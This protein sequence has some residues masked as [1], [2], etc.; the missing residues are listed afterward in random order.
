M[1]KLSQYEAVP[2]FNQTASALFKENNLNIENQEDFE[3]LFPDQVT[4]INSYNDFFSQISILKNT[5]KFIDVIK[6]HN[7][8]EPIC[9]LGD[10]DVDGIMATTI[11]CHSLNKL[12]YA[13][14][15]IIPNR[16][17]DGY[18]M[19]TEALEKDILENQTTLFI[20]V[21]NGITAKESVSKVK[22]L[23]AEIII[24]DH[25]LP[26]ATLLP[27]TLIIDPKYNQDE[28]SDICGAYVAFK[29]CF[30]LYNQ[31]SPE[32]LNVIETL[33][34]LAGIATIADMMPALEE[35]RQLIQMTMN[36]INEVK[37]T[38]QKNSPLYKILY[39]LG[40]QNFFKSDTMLATEELISYSVGPAINAISRVNG[41]VYDV[42]QK[43][44]FCLGKPWAYIPSYISMN[45]ARQ[46]MSKE[47]FSD[48]KFDKNYNLSQV[49]IY[50][51]EEYEYNIKGILG[52]IA[53]RV[54]NKFKIVSLIGSYKDNGSV[55]FS[56]RSTPNYDLHTGID[57]LKELL[58][59]LGIN[60]GGHSQAMGV[61]IENATEDNIKK[62]KDALEED[63]KTHSEP[64]VPTV[65][66]WEP[67]ME[68]EIIG[69]MEALQPYGANFS[70]LKFS[71]SGIFLEYDYENKIA[72]ISDYKFRMF[73]P[74][75]EI[76]NYIGTD[77]D[78]MFTV[79]F[80]SSDGPIFNVIN[81]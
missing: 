1:K 51:P 6:Q 33:L 64:Y 57:R 73:I 25:H 22:E 37:F 46:R 18:G 74:N 9:I 28:F 17:N 48:F 35:N 77:I 40:G 3:K 27:E 66:E 61:R 80:N 63:I 81:E 15:F 49:F 36:I 72:I 23:G 69:T 30:A 20:T 26:D 13:T 12:G 31:V 19:Q 24:T 42:V 50:N 34:P 78:I 44:I 79:S 62:F 76:E 58:P 54:A 45:Y 59:D 2:G 29:L 38:N 70:K 11:M 32:N 47:L 10:Y 14:H 39:S 52:L 5:D 56:G 7:K 75:E 71:Y 8:Q 43:I 60:G 67:E 16:L 68:Q 21:D 55:E 4:P 41:D 65:F 53:N